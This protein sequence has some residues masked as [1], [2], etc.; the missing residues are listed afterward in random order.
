MVMLI[1]CFLAT[2]ICTNGNGL[3][4]YQSKKS[5][6]TPVKRQKIISF[7]TCA[8]SLSFMLQFPVSTT[9]LLPE[10]LKVLSVFLS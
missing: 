9:S 10:Y 1:I 5:I 6:L 8:G 2:D 4:L 3:G 7:Y